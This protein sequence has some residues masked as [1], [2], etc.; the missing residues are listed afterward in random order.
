MARRPSVSPERILAAAAHEFAERGYAGARVDRIA[1]RARVNKAMLYY[2]FASKRNL[3][4]TLLR[5][6]FGAL[7]SELRQIADTEAP[8]EER[9]RLAVT[10]IAGFVETHA[11]FPA[12]M[13][14]EMAEGGAH[15]DGE[16]LA[17]L[18]ALPRA[19]TAILQPGITT[20][21]F[22]AMHPIASYFTT[23]A[24][25]IMFV[26][27]APLRKQLLARH[28]LPPGEPLTPPLF[29][30]QLTTSLERAFTNTPTMQRPAH[31]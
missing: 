28:L 3:Y 13:L 22:R 5:D 10:A 19:F 14:R 12:V 2:H 11:F 8:P 20:G 17:A 1:R 29:L 4:R 15:L 21:Y 18:A 23:I 31:A 16:T 6:T 7:G 26:A 9:L 27:S 25:I 30:T 24:P